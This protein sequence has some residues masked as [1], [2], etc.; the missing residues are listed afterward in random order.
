MAKVDV[1][2]LGI[3]GTPV[4]DGNC[5]KLVRVS[6]DAAKELENTEIGGV[7]TDFIT[8]AD[9]KIAICMHCQYCIENR[10]RCKVD[11]DVHAVYDAIKR[12]DGVIFGGHVWAET[13]SPYLPILFSR[14]RYIA[15]FTNEFRN[16][17][18]GAITLG[19]FGTGAEQAL[20]AIE[21]MIYGFGIIPVRR[22]WAVASRAAFGERA[23]YL[24]HGV[25]DDSAGVSR[26]KAVGRRVVEIARMIKYATQAGIIT[27]EAPTYTGAS[28][29]PK[30]KKFIEGVWRDR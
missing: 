26:V 5:D 1:R 8:M 28:L 10:T 14:G 11:D 18:G 23:S 2:I 30:E 29:I 7:E 9:K 4:K 25:L 20:A 3:S 17:V 19:W 16:K 13:I 15:F 12:A 6:L 22:G 24:E 21:N 27:P